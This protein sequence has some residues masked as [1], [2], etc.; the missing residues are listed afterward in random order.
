[1]VEGILV[2]STFLVFLG[3]IVYTRKSYVAK[4]DMQQNTRSATLYYASH[5][6]SGDPGEAT[7]GSGGVVEGGSE[8]ADNAARKSN[9]PSKAAVNRSWNTA[10]SKLEGTVKWQ[11]VWDKN[12]ERGEKGHI[13]LQKN[14]LSRKI[15]AESYVTCNEKKYDSQWTAWIQFAADFFKTGGGA[16]DIFK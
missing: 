16:V 11:A 4:L 3:L 8:K 10:S 6:C 15:T 2:I 13:D 9:I 14:D 7:M 1:M 12:A 5:G